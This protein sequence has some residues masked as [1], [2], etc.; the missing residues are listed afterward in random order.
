MR[1]QKCGTPYGYAEHV[2]NRTP[3]CAACR[4]AHA[5]RF[6][7][8]AAR[9]YLN[10]GPLIVDATG[11]RRRL[12]ALGAIGWSK[13]ELGAKV[14]VTGMAVNQWR[15]RD[16]VQVATAQ[17]VA[18]LYAEL[19]DIPG[20]NE[21]SRQYAARAGWVPPI[22]WDDDTIDDP[23]AQPFAEQVDAVD[24]VAI[25]RAMRGDNSIQLSRAERLEAVRLLT[26]QGLSSAEIATRL[27]K[28]Q[29]A[30]VRDRAALSQQ[31]SA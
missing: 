23:T 30:V 29:R 25:H 3:K 18:A 19:S 14:G 15:T 16:R 1:T 4:R 7:R 17:R 24:E 21:R 20:T 28:H 27:G 10:R 12:Q 22:G 8:Y 5:D 9:R 26:T 13:T 11:T 31:A 6:K 2:R